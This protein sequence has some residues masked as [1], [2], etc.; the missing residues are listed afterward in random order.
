M[1]KQRCFA[2]KQRYKEAK[3]VCLLALSVDN[4]TKQVCF[5]AR[6][7]YFAVKQIDKMARHTGNTPASV[8]NQ[9]QQSSQ[10]TR[11]ALARTYLRS[12]PT[13]LEAATLTATS[14]VVLF[15]KKSAAKTR[16]R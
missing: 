3:Q 16:T 12:L 1:T 14:R 13:S 11:Q 2:L 10:T 8:D 9:T 6:Q 15:P 4:M 5:L 7:R